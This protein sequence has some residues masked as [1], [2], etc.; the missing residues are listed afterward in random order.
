MAFLEP[1]KIALLLA[2]LTGFLTPFDLCHTL[3]LRDL[4]L[5]CAGNIM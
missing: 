4:L 5:A 3:L 1:K 2:V